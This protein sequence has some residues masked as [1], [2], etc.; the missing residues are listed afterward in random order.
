MNMT[1]DSEAPIAAA[2][3]MR[4]CWT[5]RVIALAVLV[6]AAIL[7]FA[8]LGHY[9]LWDDEALTALPALGVWR[10]GDTTAV[11]GD[12]ILGYQNGSLLVGLRERHTPPLGF[13]LAAPSLGLLGQTA[14]AAR[15][16]F[17]LCGLAS[18]A[19]L[20]LGLKKSH[21]DLTTWI[22][23][24]EAILGNVSFFLYC[25]QCRYYAPAILATS[26]LALLYVFWD[27][28]KRSVAAFALL[29]VVL[30]AANYLNYV[31]LYACLAADYLIWGRQRRPLTAGDWLRL[32]FP[33][34]LLGTPIVLVW[35]PLGKVEVYY[36]TANWFADKATLFWW[37]WRD[38]NRCEFG[39]VSLILLAPLFH[40]RTR[41]GGLLRLALGAFIYVV[42]ITIASPQPLSLSSVVADVRYLAPMIPLCMMI[43]VLCLR[44]I[45][46]KP[47][48]AALL[49]MVVFGTSLLH[50]VP[51][52]DGGLRSAIVSYVQELARPPGDPYT[53]TAHWVNANVPSGCSVFV[54]PE[55]MVY[56]LMFHAPRAL[57]AWQ[58]AAP[59]RLSSRG[60]P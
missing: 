27:G 4:E 37:N 5:K 58:F 19:V 33:Q 55:Y 10:T 41:G 16:P 36:Q 8:R 47:I 20:L 43:G 42:A 13:Y 46:P 50:W 45:A 35:N 48:P 28:R 30:L 15:L 17:A 14:W 38:L 18:V 26:A 31:A 21:A 32:V 1:Y 52:F 54:A 39:V 40:A 57:Y 23:M 29:S 6:G 44:E 7:L 22:L 49:G 24:A 11:I 25:R 59:P 60:S 12:N 56:P 53:T 9:A 3:A 2:P 34:V 51:M